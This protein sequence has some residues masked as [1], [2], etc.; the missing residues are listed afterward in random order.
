LLKD[1]RFRFTPSAGTYFQC[2][3]YSEI[4]D[5]A[6]MEFVSWMTKEKGVAAIPLSAFYEKVPDSRIIRFCFCKDNSTLEQAAD[7]LRRL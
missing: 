7:I 3:D 2:V 6:D 5:K 1:T 4:S